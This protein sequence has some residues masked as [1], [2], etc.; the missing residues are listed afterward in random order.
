MSGHCVRERVAIT[1]NNNMIFPLV[2]LT[3]PVLI[4]IALYTSNS[5]EL[6]F[7]LP[8]LKSTSDAAAVVAVTDSLSPSESRFIEY[9]SNFPKVFQSIEIQRFVEF[10]PAAAVIDANIIST[11]QIEWNQ[12]TLLLILTFS[13]LLLRY[14]SV[15]KAYPSACLSSP[16]NDSIHQ[17][18][19]QKRINSFQN[20]ILLLLGA[21]QL[22]LSWKQEFLKNLKTKPTES[23]T[24]DD[25]P[26][27][28]IKTKSVDTPAT[29]PVAAKTWTPPSKPPTALNSPT[30]SL[31]S[32]KSPASSSVKISISPQPSLYSLASPQPSTSQ[33]YTVRTRSLSNFAAPFKTSQNKFVEMNPATPILSLD[34]LDTDIIDNNTLGI[35][36]LQQPQPRPNQ[37]PPKSPLFAMQ[38]V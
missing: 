31:L 8:A 13:L 21:K 24:L 17:N 27:I 2:I 22:P 16:S 32:L 37:Q 4:L 38:V 19:L 33:I 12:E 14:I 18:I 1:K 29:K 10:T 28:K 20:S 15:F 3:F 9:F 6:L 25:E 35:Q 11:A 7:S 23:A 36:T 26:W 30:P 5:F 34:G